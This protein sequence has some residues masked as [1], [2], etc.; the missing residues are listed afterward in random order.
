MSSTKP[1]W[2]LTINEVWSLLNLSS[3]CLCPLGHSY[4]HPVYFISQE[5]FALSYFLAF[6]L[7]ISFFL[8]VPF[9]S[10]SISLP[11][12]PFLPNLNLCRGHTSSVPT[13]FSSTFT[14]PS[15]FSATLYSSPRPLYVTTYTTGCTCLEY[16]RKTWYG[17]QGFLS[18]PQFLSTFPQNHVKLFK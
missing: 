1:S 3:L 2:E 4:P 11:P 6:L 16:S 9:C 17:G 10:V 14:S 12:P 5:I 13:S 15:G 7:A 18:S 8:K